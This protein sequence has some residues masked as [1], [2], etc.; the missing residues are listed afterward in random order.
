[1]KTL[2]L[3]AF[4]LLVV[5]INAQYQF[6][7]IIAFKRERTCLCISFYEHYAVFVGNVS[8][9]GKNLLRTYFTVQVQIN[10]KLTKNNC[11]KY[12]LVKNNCE[13]LATYVRYGK[14]RSEQRGTPAGPLTYFCSRDKRRR[15]GTAEDDIPP[16]TDLET[17]SCDELCPSSGGRK[18]GRTLVSLICPLLVLACLT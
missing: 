17:V 9:A 11:E 6:G 18:S 7:D 13:H 1:M 15:R 16:L 10:V 5:V 12:S 4:L 2:I 14:K 3:A 8:I